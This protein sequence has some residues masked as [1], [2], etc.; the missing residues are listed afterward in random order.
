ML[1]FFLPS[2]GLSKAAVRVSLVIFLPFSGGKPVLLPGRGW[3]ALFIVFGSW[4]QAQA[5]RGPWLSSSL[6]EPWLEIWLGPKVKP[7]PAKSELQAWRGGG[8]AFQ[9]QDTNDRKN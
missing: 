6:L 8:K 2:F 9:N 5:G 4:V 7:A 1:S 3:P